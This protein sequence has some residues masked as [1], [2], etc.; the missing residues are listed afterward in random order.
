MKYNRLSISSKLKDILNIRH[1][2]ARPPRY[3]KGARG[4]GKRRKEGEVGIREE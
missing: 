3:I 2:E 1:Q 4:G